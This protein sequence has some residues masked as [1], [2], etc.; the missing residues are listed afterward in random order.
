VS[1]LPERPAS[2]IRDGLLALPFLAVV[3]VL[4]LAVFWLVPFQWTPP[5]FGA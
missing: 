2:Q 4:C 5:R 1:A 3:V